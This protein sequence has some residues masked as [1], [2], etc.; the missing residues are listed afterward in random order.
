MRSIPTLLVALLLMGG[1]PPKASSPVQEPSPP[2]EPSP[3][4]VD[5]VDRPTC[6]AQCLHG[7]RTDPAAM[8]LSLE[9]CAGYRGHRANGDPVMTRACA[10]WFTE[11]P[12]MVQDCR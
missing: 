6:C 12:L 3:S 8:D 9:P 7:A 1:C 5:V 10:D 11:H 4:A 2:P